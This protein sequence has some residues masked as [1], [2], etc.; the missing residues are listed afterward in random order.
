MKKYVYNIEEYNLLKEIIEKSETLHEV[1]VLL[2]RNT[3]SCTY[4]NIKRK[5]LFYK[6]DIS[7]FL[8]RSEKT[9]KLYREGKLKK[10]STEELFKN[11]THRS[12]S[13]IKNRILQENLLEYKC[14]LCNQSD[15]WLGKKIS[16]ILDHINGNRNDNNLENLRFVCPNCNATLDTHCLGLRVKKPKEKK[17]KDLYFVKREYKPKLSLRKV[18]RPSKEELEI[19]MENNSFCSIGRQYGVS[20]NAVRKW[21]KIYKLL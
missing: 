13:C 7:H 5:I 4:T 3:S 2:G 17:I 20:D 6:I 14:S 8:T 16:L 10:I 1:L 15:I 18:N 21:A 19:L 12:R 9:K 11:N